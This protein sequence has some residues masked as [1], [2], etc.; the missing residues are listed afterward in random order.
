MLSAGI[1]GRSERDVAWDLEGAIR[2]AG[3]EGSSF[4]IIVAAAERGA[5]PHA[6]PGPEPIPPDS[7]VVIDL[8]A[9]VEG[10]CSD[11]T[12]MACTGS[13]PDELSR[14]WRVCHDAQAAA[15]EAVRPGLAASALDAL[16]REI[17][18]DAGFGENFGHGLGH[19]VGLDIHE[20]PGVRSEGREELKSGMVITVEP[21]VYIEG[22]GGVRVEDLLVV[23]DDGPMVLST[24]DKEEPPS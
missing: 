7:L 10:Y 11:M 19:G 14:A 12:R 1:V 16:A 2:G 6:V 8:G 21:G 5:R 18:D 15:V 13:L 23:A 9:R 3:G 24:H 4:D 22:V 20:R 17:I